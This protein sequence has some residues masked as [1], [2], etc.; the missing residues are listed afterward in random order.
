MSV[1]RTALRTLFRVM[2]AFLAVGAAAAVARAA[3]ETERRPGYTL[4]YL[5]GLIMCLALLAIPCKRFR[6]T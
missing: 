1:A 6:H 5:A 3:E 2:L 4:T